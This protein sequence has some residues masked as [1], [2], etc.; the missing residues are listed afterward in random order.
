MKFLSLPT[1]LLVAAVAIPA[2]LLLYFLKLR[3]RERTVSSTLLWKRA[4]QDLQVNAP[5]QKLRKNLLLFLQLLILAAILFALANPVANFIKRPKRNIV[6]LIDR[7]ASMKTREADGRIRLAHAKDGAMDLVDSLQGDSRAMVL[8]FADRAEVVSSFTE[9]HRRLKRQIEQIKPTDG[10]S[11]LGEA[12]QLAVAY[13]ANFAAGAVDKAVRGSMETADIDL[14]S[15]GR[16]KDA[17]QQFVTRGRMTYYRVGAATD[18]AGIVAFDVRRDIER[19]GEVSVFVQVENF[20]PK[21]ITS[22]VSLSLGRKMETVQQVT[23]GPAA[24]TTTRPANSVAGA[25]RRTTR[26]TQTLP[27]SRNVIFKMGHSAGGIITVK[28]HRADALATDNVVTAPIDPPRAIRVLA[29]SDRSAIRDF[30][31]Q[32]FQVAF[33]I[34]D[35]TL[36]TGSQYEEAG[37]DVLAVEGR[38]TFD[39]VVFDKHDTDRLWPGNYVFFGGIPKIPGISRGDEVEDQVFVTWRE[40]H[41][42][43]RYVRLDNIFALKWSRLSLP[44]HAVKLIEGEDSTI[45]A[46]ITDPGHR[47]VI[48]AFDLM[49]SNFIKNPASVIFLQ[50]AMMYLAG[51]GLTG[52]TRLITPGDTLS[53]PIPPGARSVRV[54]RPGGAVDQIDVADRNTATYART[55]DCGIYKA[56]FDDAGKTTESYA[57]NILDANESLIAPNE[58]FTIG[59]EA[60]QTVSSEIKA[61]EPLWPYAAAAALVVLL[62]EW[63]IYNKRVMI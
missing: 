56:V 16:I 8:S 42:L 60:V 50:N 27:S 9:D 46:F 36:M 5:F 40:D 32:A 37:D 19:P 35:F 15:D 12:L 43:L 38:S 22:D 6:I 47:Y 7:S 4:V 61:N 52:A 54:T 26:A 21:Q 49:D 2:L 10:P 31:Q 20:G 25:G 3:R 14:F 23:L 30:L 53:I 44:S 51:G 33:R 28:L 34:K 62:L 24:A 45:L 29:V 63:W 39:L 55:R 58:H 18:N 17:D 13:S 59:A 48:S 11:K 41:P 57:A 1:G